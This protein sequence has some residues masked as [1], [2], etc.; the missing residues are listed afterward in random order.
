MVR[1]DLFGVDVREGVDEGVGE[2]ANDFDTG[3]GRR[4]G[5]GDIDSVGVAGGVAG[6]VG[7]LVLGT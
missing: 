6:K 5:L 3:S 1:Y 4:D 2:G 7:L